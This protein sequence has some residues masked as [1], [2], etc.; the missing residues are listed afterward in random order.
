MCVCNNIGSFY[1]A[2]PYIT[3]VKWPQ[4]VCQIVQMYTHQICSVC[5][6]DARYAYLGHADRPHT[7]HTTIYVRMVVCDE[8]DGGDRMR[9]NCSVIVIDNKRFAD[10]LSALTVHKIF[11]NQLENNNM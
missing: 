9:R 4:M 5:V 6:Y 10:I 2:M 1:S 8:G 3:A 11:A 7:T